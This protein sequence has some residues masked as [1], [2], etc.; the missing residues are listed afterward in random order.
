MSPAEGYP[1]GNWRGGGVSSVVGVPAASRSAAV[2]ALGHVGAVV[3]VE[4]G[5]MS[6]R[7]AAGP[8]GSVVKIARVY[9]MMDHGGSAG[10]PPSSTGVMSVTSMPT[11]VGGVR[12]ATAPPRGA[13]AGVANRSPSIDGWGARLVGPLL[14]LRLRT[15]CV[16]RMCAVSVSLSATNERLLPPSPDVGVRGSAGRV[17][18]KPGRP[19][20]MSFTRG[21]ASQVDG[22]A[23]LCL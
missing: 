12:E 15:R 2:A 18:N 5:G 19:L 20:P 13:A 11:V 16:K 4:A 3:G 9:G 17:K 22:G 14:L 7:L 1:R 21:G 6:V 8:E 23:G 10:G